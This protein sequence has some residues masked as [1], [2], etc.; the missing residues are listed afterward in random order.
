MK[1]QSIVRLI[2]RPWW[3]A[4]LVGLLVLSGVLLPS[5][6]A[7]QS[8]GTIIVIS[9]I[10]PQ[11][12][13]RVQA[14][15]RCTTG[16]PAQVQVEIQGGWTGNTIGGGANCQS[17]GVSA[18]VAFCTATKVA[19]KPASSCTGSGTQ[20]NATV[21][22]TPQCGAL[23]FQIPKNPISSWKVTCLFQG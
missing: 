23:Y 21:F 6:V 18:L 13:S 10:G 15:D 11:V 20:P 14:G 1:P 7:A 19:S 9:G 17:A 3:R 8:P 2:L 12:T 16:K 22:P 5:A 4:I